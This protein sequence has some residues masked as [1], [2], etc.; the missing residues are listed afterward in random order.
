MRDLTEGRQTVEVTGSTVRQVVRDAANLGIEVLT[1]YVF[2]AENW[3][4]P[5]L[6]TAGLMRLIEQAAREELRE[7]DQNGVRIRVSG[8]VEGLPPALQAELHRDIEA[9]VGNTR[10]TLNLCIN[11]G[12]R[13]EILEAAKRLVALARRGELHEDDVTAVLFAE[14]LYTKGLPDPDLL[15][16]TAGEMRVSNYLLWQI[17]YAEIWV[18]DT[19]WPDFDTNHLIAALLDYQKRVRKFGA[20]VNA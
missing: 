17:A 20:V 10:L 13:V 4:R 12:G 7:L 8:H 6:E 18:T 14:H 15:I 19:L 1:L 11:Y 2:S 9:T 16:R 5:A 3:K